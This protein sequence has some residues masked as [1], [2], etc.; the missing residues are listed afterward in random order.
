MLGGFVS[1][2]NAD[3]MAFFG[4][5]SAYGSRPLLVNPADT[6]GTRRYG[7]RA[8]W[9]EG[10][11]ARSLHDLGTIE[12]CGSCRAAEKGDRLGQRYSF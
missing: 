8:W 2:P 7:G 9:G 1:A 5:Y 4:W 3:V 11:R 6:M 10:R 12:V